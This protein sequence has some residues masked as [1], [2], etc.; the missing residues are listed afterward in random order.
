MRRG[1]LQA[2]RLCTEAAEEVQKKPRYRPKNIVEVG[3]FLPEKGVGMK[4]TRNLWIRNGYEHSYWTIT[5]VLEK[6]KGKLRYYG[7]LTWKGVESP[8][9]RKVRTQMKRG[10]RYILEGDQKALN[11]RTA[12]DN[13]PPWPM[14]AQ[15]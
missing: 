2:R 7:R 8:A 4:F 5:K 6:N 13:P 10:W 3:S 15:Q 1:F 9:E 11:G 12:A 14:Q